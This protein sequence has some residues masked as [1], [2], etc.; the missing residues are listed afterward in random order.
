MRRQ[1]PEQDEKGACFRLPSPLTDA[2]KPAWRFGVGASSHSGLP[3][4]LRCT[5]NVKSL[6]AEESLKPLFCAETS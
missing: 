6:D 2:H 1:N 3:V 4:H 5:V